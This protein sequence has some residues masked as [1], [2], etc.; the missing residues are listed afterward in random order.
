[1]P[2]SVRPAEVICTR[3]RYAN[4]QC[5]TATIPP[6]PASSTI[7]LAPQPLPFFCGAGAGGRWV[8][9]AGFSGAGGPGLGGTSGLTGAGGAAALDSGAGGIGVKLA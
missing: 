9:R 5:T 3:G 4:I 6:M 8:A 1:M 2:T 7:T